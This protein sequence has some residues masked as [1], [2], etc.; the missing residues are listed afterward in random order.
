MKRNIF[1]CFFTVNSRDRQDSGDKGSTRLGWGWAEGSGKEKKL[2]S[3]RFK[4]S[5]THITTFSH[6]KL[7]ECRSARTPL[8]HLFN[9]H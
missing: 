1:A 7:H 9:I 2:R 3:P 8:K 4:E 5:H 6:V